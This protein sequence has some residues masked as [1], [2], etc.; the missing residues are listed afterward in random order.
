MKRIYLDALILCASI[1]FAV[2]IVQ[3]DLVHQALRSAGD[4]VWLASLLGGLFF[5]SFVSSP[6]AATVLGELAREGN[7]IEVTVLGAL[8]AVI[9]DYILY[10]FVK[11]RIAKDAA[12]LLKGPRG[13]KI[14]RI[15]KQRHF[16][17]ILP[18]IGALI[19]ASPLPDELGLALLGVSSV[20]TRSFFI[21]AFTM[22]ALGIF[23]IALI[24]RSL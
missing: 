5:T 21:I 6:V 8:G 23:L 20:R 15:F 7:I 18:F 22:N 4:G 24:A 9:G 10:A 2:Y 1:L 19:I 17:R 13:R 11:H 14:L 3:S 16:R 12:Q